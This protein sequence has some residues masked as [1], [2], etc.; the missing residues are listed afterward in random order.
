MLF[1]LR[2]Q[3]SFVL[4]HGWLWHQSPKFNVVNR[5]SAPHGSWII[6][7]IQLFPLH[8]YAHFYQTAM[9]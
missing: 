1:P 4:G 7:L 5:D 9:L 2:A 3:V 8:P 6:F